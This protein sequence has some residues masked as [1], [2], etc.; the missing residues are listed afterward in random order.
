M[1]DVPVLGFI[2]SQTWLD[3]YV[4]EKAGISKTDIEAKIAEWN[5][6]GDDRIWVEMNKPGAK[7]WI[8]K[9]N[10]IVVGFIAVLKGSEGSSI[11]ALHILPQ[12]QGQGIGTELLKKALELLGN[13]KI[14]LEVVEYN[15]KAQ[16]LYKKFGFYIVGPAVTDPIILPSGNRIPKLLMV[17]D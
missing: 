12:Y 16:E 17:K 14:S 7:T 4:N 15:H 9:D 8:A 5:K 11:E 6:D 10:D 2:Q 3:S 1:D 13:K